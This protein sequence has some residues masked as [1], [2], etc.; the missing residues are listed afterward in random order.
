MNYVILPELTEE[1]MMRWLGS[2]SQMAKLCFR[3]T[4]WIVGCAA[5]FSPEMAKL[6]YIENCLN[7][8]T[9]GALRAYIFL[10]RI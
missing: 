1:G 5:S 6:W 4:D 9:R 7:E 10:L 3:G 2:S 8:F